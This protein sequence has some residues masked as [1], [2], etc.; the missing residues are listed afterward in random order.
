MILQIVHNG[1]MLIQAS[2]QVPWELRDPAIPKD[3]TDA[4]NIRYESPMNTEKCT[5]AT[6]LTHPATRN[7]GRRR[8]AHSA[9]NVDAAEKCG[10]DVY[11]G[12]VQQLS[13]RLVPNCEHAAGSAFEVAKKCAGD[14]FS[15]SGSDIL[16]YS[17]VSLGGARREPSRFW[18]G[19]VRNRRKDS[20][21]SVRSSKIIH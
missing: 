16:R 11:N 18:I 9:T 5:V 13:R 14:R 19:A 7:S 8:T 21:C 12:R 3:E 10:K 2:P 15:L 20:E 17:V 4:A 1:M 6:A